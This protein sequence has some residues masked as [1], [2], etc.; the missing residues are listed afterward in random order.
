[1]H[2]G[3]RTCGD[4]RVGRE[5]PHKRTVLRSVRRPWK[6]VVAARPKEVDFVAA[7]RTVFG[8]PGAA[9][10]VDREALCIAVTGGEDRLRAVR[11][12]GMHRAVVAWASGR[13]DAT[14]VQQ[15]VV[16]EREQE[17]AIRS[18]HQ[19]AARFKRV[20]GWRHRHTRLR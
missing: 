3:D 17:R 20:E 13:I 14:H 12:D 11:L 7:T 6:A 16:A 8:A 5:G 2:S 18:S 10:M 19:P 4:R 9:E 1:M 15:P